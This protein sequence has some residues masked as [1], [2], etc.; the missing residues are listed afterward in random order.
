MK[1]DIIIGN[2]AFNKRLDLKIHKVLE[3]HADKI[4]F[5]HPSA[6]AI[7]HKDGIHKNECEEVDMSKFESLHLFWGNELFNIGLFVPV[8]VSV[9]KKDKVGNTVKVIDDAFTKTTY[10]C[11]CNMVHLHGKM[12]PDLIKWLN[13]NVDFT[14]NVA[15]HGGRKVDDKYGFSVNIPDELFQEF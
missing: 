1:F 14:D 8:C 6:F 13:E 4:V 7:S 10:D 11:D 9:W 2:P 12:Y 15:K 3:K 5:V